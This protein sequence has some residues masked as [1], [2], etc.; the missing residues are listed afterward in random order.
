M[1]ESPFLH[2]DQLR[3]AF[4][5]SFAAPWPVELPQVDAIAIHAGGGPCAFAQTAIAALRTDLRVTPVASPRAAM[6]GVTSFRGALIAVWDLGR[7]LHGAPVERVRW[8]AVL[9]DETAAVAFDR[10]DGR[11]R[12]PAP[13]ASV[14]E[15]GGT[16]YPVF[17]LAAAV[18]GAA[19]ARS[20]RGDRHAR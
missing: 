20:G 8:C 19:P 1:S 2:A 18:A 3:A 7:L 13:L 10:L 14:V 9:R 11:L 16:I 5:Q 6:L 12:V 4:D 17:D 15:L